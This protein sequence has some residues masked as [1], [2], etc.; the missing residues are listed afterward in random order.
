MELGNTDLAK[1]ILL[2]QG[3]LNELDECNTIDRGLSKII[4]AIGRKGKKEG[5]N[6]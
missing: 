2:E 4:E 5:V 1:G 6:R 3:E